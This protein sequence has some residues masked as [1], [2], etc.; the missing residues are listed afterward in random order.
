[1]RWLTAVIVFLNGLF[2]NGNG[3][4]QPVQNYC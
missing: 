4:A 2:S 3:G 1:M